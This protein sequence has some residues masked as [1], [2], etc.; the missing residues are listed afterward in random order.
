[1][2]LLETAKE[3]KIKSPDAMTKAR[4]KFGPN[5]KYSHFFC[6]K[7]NNMPGYDSTF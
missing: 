2:N 4:P 7:I 6:H 3:Q 5:D 1:M